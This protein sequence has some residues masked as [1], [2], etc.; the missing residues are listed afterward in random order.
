MG[1]TARVAQHDVAGWTPSVLTEY[2]VGR[3]IWAAEMVA[4][5]DKPVAEVG[6][7]QMISPDGL[8]D[9]LR[10]C[11]KLAS[12]AADVR[13]WTRTAS[14]NRLRYGFYRDAWVVGALEFLDAAELPDADRAWISGLLFGY[15]SDAIQRFIN[16]LGATSPTT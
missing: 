2:E 7:R 15:R 11:L 4:K 14:G 5:C 8:L 3:A 10:E 13:I 16:R 6:C 12:E 1:Q 9:D